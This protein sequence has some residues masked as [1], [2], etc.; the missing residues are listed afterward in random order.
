MGA[1]VLDA[2]TK[3]L[4][5]H[6]GQVAV[7]PRVTRV[8]LSGRPPLLSDDRLTIAGCAYNVSG[9]PSPC[10]SVQWSKAATRVRFEGGAPL[11]S[12]SVGVCKNAGGAPQ[13]PAV[14]S[15]FQTRVR[16]Q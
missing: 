6:G 11:L 10:H 16:A 12:A 8:R 9:S 1:F 4:C 15:G 13:G 2:G 5:P 14:V 7:V 3:I